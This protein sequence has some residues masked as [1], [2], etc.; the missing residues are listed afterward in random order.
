MWSVMFKDILKEQQPIVYQTLEHQLTSNKLAHAY[1]FCGP[2]G[3]PKMETAILMTQSLVCKH[4]GFACETCDDCLRVAHHN[5]ADMIMMD[6]T[7]TSIKKDQIMKLQH[8]FNKT[9]L[10]SQ[11]KKIYIINHAENATPD[12]MNSLLKFLEEPASDMMAILLVEQLDRVLPTIVSRCQII[13]FTPLSS[14]YC[15]EASIKNDIDEFDAYMLSQMIRNVDEIIKTSQED[16]YQHGRYC[17][18]GFIERLLYR[19][20][21]ALLFLQLE[22]L[23]SKNKAHDKKAMILFTDMLSVFFKDCLRDKIICQ[24][25]WYQKQILNI[26]EKNWNCSELLSILMKEKDRLIR[27]SVNVGLLVDQ[28]F[29]KIKEVIQ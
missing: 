14:T 9:G 6:G 29:Y 12:A 4:D 5:Y 28:L 18:K 11:G 23:S 27:S 10:E 3:T 19:P 17:F 7:D 21:D 25:T 13:S 26:K 22:G 1:M 2:A 8:E 20:H 16:E 15:Y 24:D